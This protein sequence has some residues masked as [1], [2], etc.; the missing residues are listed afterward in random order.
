MKIVILGLGFFLSTQQ[1]MAQQSVLVLQ[2]PN[3]NKNAYYEVG[4]QL[5]FYLPGKRS[6]RT[7]TILGLEDSLIVFRGYTVLVSQITA[8]HID[9]QTRWWL[10]YKPAQLALMA[11]TGYI[12][13]D[14]VNNRELNKGTLAIGGSLIGLGLIF[15]LLIPN[16]IRIRRKTKLQILTV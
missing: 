16:K 4:D 10:R 5:T 13:L 12:V 1:I 9:D 15:R 3:P 2:M 11:G 14:T 6:R 7:E 8:L